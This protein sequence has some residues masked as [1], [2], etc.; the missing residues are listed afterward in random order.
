MRTIF[1]NG[2]FDLLHPGHYNLLNFCRYMAGEDG[3]VVVAINSD[4]WIKENAERPA[5]ITEN[6]RR[7]N[8]KLLRNGKHPMVDEIYIVDTEEQLLKRMQEEK[9]DFIVKGSEWRDKP[10]TGQNIAQVIFYKTTD[11]VFGKLSSSQIFDCVKKQLT[12]DE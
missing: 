5:A 6:F 3:R 10:V 12:D 8:L 4:E 1:T 9:P 11:S 7:I 2:K